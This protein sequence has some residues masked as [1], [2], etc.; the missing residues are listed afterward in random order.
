MPDFKN[1]IVEK[2]TSQ[3]RTKKC[4]TELDFSVFNSDV[5]LV[6]LINVFGARLSYVTYIDF[7]GQT[8]PVYQQ[9]LGSPIVGISAFET[10]VKTILAGLGFQDNGAFAVE[11][12]NSFINYDKIFV[13]VKTGP[14]TSMDVEV[15]FSN[16]DCSIH[17][18][19]F[20]EDTFTGFDNIIPYSIFNNG[21]YEIV[22]LQNLLPAVCQNTSEVLDYVQS[23]NH[24]VGYTIESTSL[25][26]P[27]D[28]KRVALDLYNAFKSVIL[29][30]NNGSVRNVVEGFVANQVFFRVP[31]VEVDLSVE[32]DCTDLKKIKLKDNTGLYNAQ[33]NIGG[34][35]NPNYPELSNVTKTALNI[36]DGS[37]VL[38]ATIPN[39]GYVPQYNPDT[40]IYL[41]ANQINGIGPEWRRNKQYNFEYILYMNDGNT[42]SCGLFSFII[43]N[44]GESED[45]FTQLEDC[46]LSQLKALFEKECSSSC[47]KSEQRHIDKL[48]SL[49]TKMEILKSS[50]DADSSCVSEADITKLLDECKK[51]C[52]GC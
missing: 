49:K 34:Y 25:I 47:N 12:A 46:I 2:G 3:L 11:N 21:V 15:S 52:L 5:Q 7:L 48:I 43:D 39:L 17:D 44:C 38:I 50:M 28:T 10:H 30:F 27:S 18:I 16:S 45:E 33:T 35:G 24:I 40:F 23:K 19:S 13:T 37:N 26:H 42:Y 14:S 22:D 9:V 32:I 4:T 41:V 8:K 6:T 20:A 36:Y 1:C 31:S 29:W 51:G